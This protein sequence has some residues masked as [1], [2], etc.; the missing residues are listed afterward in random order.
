MYAAYCLH[1]QHKPK[2]PTA[3][4]SKVIGTALRTLRKQFPGR[5]VEVA[6]DMVEWRH[7]AP[8]QEFYRGKNDRAK[9]YL[10]LD[11]LFRAAKLGENV[12]GTLAWKAG[13]NG[14]ELDP[15][16]AAPGRWRPS[17]SPTWTDSDDPDDLPF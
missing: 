3:A 14:A 6:V 9:S 7:V 13:D 2:T 8:D 1:H 16:P 15:D 4:E 5:A 12:E 11:L 10:S 17:V